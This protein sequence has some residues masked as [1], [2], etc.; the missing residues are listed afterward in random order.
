[1]RGSRRLRFGMWLEQFTWLHW[2][3]FVPDGMYGTRRRY[4]NRINGHVV[5]K[6]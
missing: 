1:M 2:W 6:P 3:L 4:L 5:M